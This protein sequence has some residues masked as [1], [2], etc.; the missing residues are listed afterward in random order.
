MINTLLSMS[1]HL[2]LAYTPAYLNNI[3]ITLAVKN[4]KDK[5]KSI[6]INKKLI[7]ANYILLYLYASTDTSK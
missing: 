3:R 5:L 7:A 6:V 2:C 1:T 4:Y